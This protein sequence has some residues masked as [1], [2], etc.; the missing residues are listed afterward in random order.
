[1]KVILLCAGYAT[2]LYPLTEDTPKPLL[3][4]ADKPIIQYL[5]DDLKTIDAV[6][7]IYIVTNDK[8]AGHF[9][10][11]CS[12]FEYPKKI[13][14]I[15][16][17][18]TTNENRLGAIGDIHFTIKK[19]QIDDDLLIIAG[20]N[21]FDLKLHDFI[22]YAEQHSPAGTIAA[23]D[24]KDRELAKKYGL[25]KIDNC[26]TI[27]D[28][29]EKPKN[30]DTTLAS[31]GLYFYP[32]PMLRLIDRYIK[33]GN[34]PDQPGNFVAWISKKEAVYSYVFDGIWFDIGDFTSLENANSYFKK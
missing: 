16:D 2:R 24:V 19:V 10:K 18:T 32:R 3:P 28:F 15:N 17:K 4:V 31:L 1:M 34:N 30:P 7:A 27:I 13:Q 23:Y 12:A 9:E 22:A 25:V 29:Q 33:E 20:D 14:V 8:F 6:D 11:W 5:L 26:G 21:I